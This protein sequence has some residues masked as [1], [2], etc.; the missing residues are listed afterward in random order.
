MFYV[1][2]IFLIVSIVSLFDNYLKKIPCYFFIQYFQGPL[3]FNGLKVFIYSSNMSL[4]MT[5]FTLKLKM[6]YCVQFHI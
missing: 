1:T 5:L 4:F 3:Y 6:V 2:I